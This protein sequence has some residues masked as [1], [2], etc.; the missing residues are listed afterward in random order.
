MK[1]SPEMMPN[2]N[3]A[4]E[5]LSSEADEKNEAGEVVASGV[6]ER[7]QKVEL[8]RHGERKSD[9]PVERPVKD[10]GSVL[11]RLRSMFKA[12]RSAPEYPDERQVF[13][14]EESVTRPQPRISE[15]LKP[16]QVVVTE[17]AT[18]NKFVGEVPDLKPLNHRPVIDLAQYQVKEKEPID[19]T[20]FRVDEGEQP[21][22][23]EVESEESEEQTGEQ[24]NVQPEEREM[25]PLEAGLSKFSDKLD[26]VVSVEG[27]KKVFATMRE[28]LAP[29]LSK[30]VPESARDFFA[31]RDVE[32]GLQKNETFQNR[33]AS[34][35]Q[36]VV[37][38]HQISEKNEQI[39]NV[40]SH[41]ARE[42]NALKD[43]ENTLKLRKELAAGDEDLVR[44]AEAHFAEAQMAI[45]EKL[46]VLEE[47]RGPLVLER[48][49]L[50]SEKEGQ[51]ALINE[52]NKR[53]K[54]FVEGRV[55]NLKAKIQFETIVQTR[56]KIKNDLTKDEKALSALTA[57]IDAYNKTIEGGGYSKEK[58]RQLKAKIKELQ[59]TRKE[60]E[61]RL[62][63]LRK[64]F[65]GTQNI[66]ATLE[67]RF[68]AMTQVL[69]KNG[70]VVE[71]V[72][73]TEQNVSNQNA[74]QPVQQNA[75]ASQASQGSASEASQVDSQGQ[76]ETT[77]E[78]AVLN[79]ESQEPVVSTSPEP[80]KQDSGKE[81]LA[82]ISKGQFN[83]LLSDI[84]KN[85]TRPKGNDISNLFKHAENYLRHKSSKESI[86]PEKTALKELRKNTQMTPQEKRAEQIKLLK[87][88]QAKLN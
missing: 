70:V 16:R 64:E 5:V 37:L 23:Q 47:Q 27:I 48:D 73:Q 76:E 74:T 36:V 19:L 81:R 43:A 68:T 13:V 86:T 8:V 72:N 3:E 62:K 84:E 4:G 87:Q 69:R 52:D 17:E 32:K 21:N 82:N 56:D 71:E 66:V 67:T 22:S 75:P 28:K 58:Q 42:K 18:K 12:R 41:I 9:V 7:G 49:Q 83:T 50:I 78:E 63:S 57:R 54:G 60:I 45:N 35:E 55:E 33:E 29:Q 1:F 59:A 80:E 51:K 61:D 25:T 10:R 88:I 65:A 11:G 20:P 34:I 38:T 79:E 77:A 40:D 85:Q 46:A 44:D 26:E 30:L 15:G 39:A 53:L 24:E 6:N 14:E 31:A 2:D